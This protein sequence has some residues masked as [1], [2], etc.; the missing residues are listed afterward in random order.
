MQAVRDELHAIV[1]RV[2][3]D[4]RSI[5]HLAEM[6]LGKRG[7]GEMVSTSNVSDP[8]LS[9]VLTGEADPARAW[10]DEFRRFRTAA[11]VLDGH[12][13][14]LAPAPPQRGRENTVEVCD[15]CQLPAPTV[16]RLDD[17][18]YHPGGCWWKAYNERSGRRPA[19]SETS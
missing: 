8:T 2:V 4:W 18:K 7:D 12:R 15:G 9:A 17:G 5:L 19:A 13:A 11:R 10:L 3:D 16:K 14:G 1:D 6:A